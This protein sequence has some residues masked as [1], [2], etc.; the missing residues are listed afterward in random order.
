MKKFYYIC[1]FTFVFVP[2]VV[3]G[4]RAPNTDVAVDVVKIMSSPQEFALT[5]QQIFNMPVTDRRFGQD[6]Y[7]NIYKRV[8][9]EAS[10]SVI[11]K[12]GEAVNREETALDLTHAARRNLTRQELAS[13]IPGYDI[14]NVLTQENPRQRLGTS[15][16][17]RRQAATAELVAE[18]KKL[19]DF[20]ALAKMDVEPTELFSN[21]NEADSGFD[22]VV[23]LNNI[24]TILFGRED[25]STGGGGGDSAAP[26]S[27]TR[28]RPSPARG[29]QSS[30]QQPP[31]GTQTPSPRGG[32]QG[33]Q[34]PAGGIGQ[35]SAENTNVVCPANGAFNNAVQ[36][37]RQ[38]E[39]SRT[40]TST[41]QSAGGQRQTSD[42]PPQT[43]PGAQPSGSTQPQT[44]RQIDCRSPRQIS[45][46]GEALNWMDSCNKTDASNQ[47]Y[48]TDEQAS[49]EDVGS[50]GIQFCIKTEALYKT[51]SSYTDTANCIACHF[52]KINDLYKRTLD[53][54][55]TASK[56]TGNFLEASKC[57]QDG[58]GGIPFLNLKW[59][60]IMMPQPILTPP[61]DDLLLKTDL[62]KNLFDF[63][64]KFMGGPEQLFSAEGLAVDTCDFLYNPNQRPQG[65]F[66]L[67][68]GSDQKAARDE[69]SAVMPGTDPSRLM[70]KISSEIA[71]KAKDREK[72]LKQFSLEKDAA[73]Q[74]QQFQ[75][76][77]PEMD[78][79]NNYFKSFAK[80]FSDM[81]SNDP[82]APCKV[83]RDKPSC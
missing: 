8:R 55:L 49:D 43:G 3:F 5:L 66:Q 54:S 48:C 56:A 45:S 17:Q 71:K 64:K 11:K 61:N 20:E 35:P 72:Q 69:L 59:N 22:L 1:A 10:D 24:E 19:A 31:A 14:S 6:L 41:G 80:L 50:V 46:F 34:Q 23:D 28:P 75:V 76:L 52:E 4:A 65:E 79:M 21:G 74:A 47:S 26:P 60:L 83:L 44:D 70:Q 63:C 25:D 57:K 73:G 38:E 51:V 29:Q 58:G 16:P 40:G 12:I 27:G 81:V 39:Q 68:P 42:A 15:E 78:A 62:F 2:L 37:A 7:K 53:R 82:D 32:S 18:E 9:Y 36:R 30:Q 67:G 33:Q 13:L 77:M